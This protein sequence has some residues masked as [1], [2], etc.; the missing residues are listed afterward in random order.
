MVQRA[1]FTDFNLSVGLCLVGYEH[2]EEFRI[3][4]LDVAHSLF[5]GA[6]FH[7][8]DDAIHELFPNAGGCSFVINCLCKYLSD[9]RLFPVTITC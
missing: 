8:L 1:A 9:K 4:L 6:Y 5:N 2:V 3:S 7:L